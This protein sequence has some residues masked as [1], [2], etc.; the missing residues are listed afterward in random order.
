MPLAQIKR[1]Q[2]LI[3]C[4]A[5]RLDVFILQ[6]FW[7]PWVFAFGA[8][9]TISFSIG[10]LFDVLRRLTA[11]TLAIST[12]LQVSVFQLPRFMV[13]ALPMSMLLAPLLT[14]SQL[15]KSNEL[16]ALRV[17]GTSLYRIV[18]PAICLSLIVALCTY[19]MSE[20]VVPPATATAN[21]LLVQHPA[22]QIAAI[23]TQ[24][25]VHRT[26]HHQHLTQLFYARTFDGEVLHQLTILQFQ[27]RQLHHIWLAKQA[28]W[29]ATQQQ[30]TLTQGTRYTIDP[31]LGLYQ[32]VMS[33]Q[34][35]PFQFASPQELAE[36]ARQPISIT[37]TRT[38]MK[39]LQRSG[40]E[41]YL[42]RLR[43]RWYSLMAFPWIGIGFALI[44]SALGCR[45]TSKQASLGFGFSSVLIFTYYTFSFICQTLGNIGLWPAS[46]AGWLPIVVLLTTGVILL[47]Q[48]NIGATYR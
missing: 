12:A 13:L 32:Q 42:Q 21:R 35:Q 5:S 33:F 31:A 23:P 22:S 27:D 16:I 47:H 11:G 37:E 24:N 36:V 26:Y 2:K 17:C 29:D 44:G 38:L 9:T 18:R 39:R 41:Q 45:S 1:C 30:W 15:A 34:Q 43:V 20:W 14:Y 46:L 10:A 48:N 25:I 8:F 6:A 19:S 28:T 7:M 3:V 4:W 40:N